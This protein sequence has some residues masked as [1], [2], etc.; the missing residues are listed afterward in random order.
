MVGHGVHPTT[1]SSLD[2][3]SNR[4]TPDH[5]TVPFATRTSSGGA[6]ARGGKGALKLPRTDPRGVAC[7]PRRCL[8]LRRSQAHAPGSCYHS[9]NARCRT[10]RDIGARRTWRGRLELLR[11]V[12]LPTPFGVRSRLQ[13]LRLGAVYMGRAC[14]YGVCRE[15][16]RRRRLYAPHS[17]INNQKE[18]VFVLVLAA[19]A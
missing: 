18:I 17:V 5:S 19:A 4:P 6:C 3:G 11:A 12:P 1:Q 10:W 15:R 2:A 14:A 8:G 9:G 13:W 16:T 7:C